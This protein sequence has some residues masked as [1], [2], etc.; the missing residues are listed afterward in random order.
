MKTF[1]LAVTAL[2]F[3]APISAAQERPVYLSG[4][5]LVDVVR[6]EVYPDIAVVI[7]AGKI[8][9][10]FF[11]FPFNAGR[12]PANALRVDVK[13]KYLVPGLIDMHFHTPTTVHGVEVDKRHF[14]RLLLKSGITTIRALAIEGGA[15]DQG[16][17]SGLIN[18]KVA[19][20]DRK[21]DG[22]NIIVSASGIIEQAPGFPRVKRTQI[23]KNPI[24][25]RELVGEYAYRGAEWIKFYNF[26]DEEM[27]RAVIDESHR[28][29]RKVWG[30][31][32]MIGAAE[33][34]RLGVDSLEHTVS[35]VQ[36]ALDYETSI[37]MTD[38]GYYRLFRLWT[39][40]NEAEVT[41]T[42]EVLVKN[43]TPIIPT[44]AVQ[45]IFVDR[46]KMARDNADVFRY[47][48]PEIYK[49]L[50]AP[51]AEGVAEHTGGFNF[52]KY[53]PKK[54]GESVKV[55]ARTI[56][57]F[58][59]MGGIVGAGSD[60]SIDIFPYAPG[61]SL[62]HELQLFVEGG[63]TPLEALRTAT[64]NAAGILGWENR[65]GSIEIGKH[66]D[67]VALNANPLAD[68]RSVADIHMVVK[69]GAAFPIS[70]L[71]NQLLGRSQ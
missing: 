38:I 58:V 39:D 21:M 40:V 30:H 25:A 17:M 42:L 34:S 59:K 10:L 32:A 15:S 61:S 44:L 45:N 54:W 63:M 19:I 60:F 26:G 9:D 65:F 7:E 55:Q 43:K 24:E 33:A 46:D 66:A 13:G 8:T 53:D 52:A 11:D 18:D 5:H 27:V 28:L 48:Q 50:S 64:I 3:F 2:L 16:A 12:V 51:A 68:I 70:T 6:G 29:G 56:A 36:K 22:P 1:F 31:F 47:Y 69:S 35:L 49:A 37:S 23:V 57:R 71:N 41:K 62:H 4:G 20:D 67:I 14:Y